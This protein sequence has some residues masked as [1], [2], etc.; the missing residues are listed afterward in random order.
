V[1]LGCSREEEKVAGTKAHIALDSAMRLCGLRW[2]GMTDL[3]GL[4][5]ML[6]ASQHAVNCGV[7]R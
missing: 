5:H 1:F 3:S 7:S 6:S 4:Q 2:S